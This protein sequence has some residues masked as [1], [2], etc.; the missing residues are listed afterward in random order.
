M[1]HKTRIT[2][3]HWSSLEEIA[4]HIGVS[5]DT[6]RAWIKKKPSHIIKWVGNINSK[7]LK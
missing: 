7:Y 6:I 1:E 5:K 3:E 2:A 4:R